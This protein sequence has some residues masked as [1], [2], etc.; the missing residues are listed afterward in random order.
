MREQLLAFEQITNNKFLLETPVVVFLTY[1]DLFGKQLNDIPFSDCFKE[2]EG[3]NQLDPCIKF[4]KKKITDI[5]N[6]S[7]RNFIVEG[8]DV[9]D[10]KLFDYTLKILKSILT[11]EE[12]QE[13]L[14]L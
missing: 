2:Y 11:T 1:K 5:N 10:P 13:A 9:N 3:S 6:N 7:K 12:K 14:G 8:I 4:I